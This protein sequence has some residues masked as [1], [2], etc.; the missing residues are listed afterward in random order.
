MLDVAG[1]LLLE[2]GYRRVIVEEVARRAGVDRG[3]VYARFPSK[4]SLFLTVLL[5][6]QRL[7]VE[8]QVR[9]MRTDPAELLPSRMARTHY[10]ALIDDP[11]LAALYSRD[12]GVLGTLADEATA[13]LSTL[14]A[15]RNQVMIEQLTVL[16]GLGCVRWERTVDNQFHVLMAIFSGWFVADGQPSAPRDRQLRADLLGETVAAALEVADPPLALVIPE[17]PR[18]ADRY[19]SLNALVEQEWRRRVG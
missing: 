7:S 19:A 1:E 14:T 16:R 2:I 3:A 5:R 12:A 11:V 10:L 18:L 6:A 9:R 17:Q 8:D 13:T 4:E 15:A